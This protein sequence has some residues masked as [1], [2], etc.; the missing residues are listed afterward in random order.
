MLYRFPL[1]AVDVEVAEI[2]GS[3]GAYNAIIQLKPWLQTEALST[4]LRMV[5]RLDNVSGDGA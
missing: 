2:P 5:A 4:S 1:S 3:A